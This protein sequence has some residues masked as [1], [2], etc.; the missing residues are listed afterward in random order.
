MLSVLMYP[1]SDSLP[2]SGVSGFGLGLVPGITHHKPRSAWV[3]Q[4]PSSGR[5]VCQRARGLCDRVV[6]NLSSSFSNMRDEIDLI[7]LKSAEAQERHVPSLGA[8]GAPRKSITHWLVGVHMH[9]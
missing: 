3:R 2:V 6:T 7:L 9:E 8:T 1:R 4:N 5:L